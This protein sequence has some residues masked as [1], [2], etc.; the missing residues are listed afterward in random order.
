MAKVLVTGGAGFIGSNLVRGA[1]RARR[2]RPRARQLL[3]RQPREP[4]RPRRRGGR[5]RAPQLRA[6][7]QRRPRHRGRLPP[8]RARLRA[9]LGAGPADL[10]RGQRRG[11]AERPARRAGRG[12][13]ARRVR[14]ELVGLRHAAPPLPAREDAAAR[15]ALA[16]RRREARGR[17]LLR[18]VLAASTRAF[19]TVVVRYF[20]VFGPRQSPFSQY[21]AVVP[22]FITAI[23]HGEPVT[24][25]GRRR[26]VARLH[27]RRRTSSTRTL[28]AGD[29]AGVERA[30]LQRRRR[31][32]RRA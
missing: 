4:R 15:P 25:D 9:A 32:R 22:L 2:R 8:R 20:N 16:L 23:A 14:V 26:A 7:P 17:A 19:E 13:A 18:L 31:A 21:A 29:A 11:D 1:A 3:D 6:R 24:I 10:E 12:R 5:G 30:D 27:L 28:R